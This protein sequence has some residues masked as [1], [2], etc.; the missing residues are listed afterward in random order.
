ILGTDY[1]D[2]TAAP[3]SYVYM[4]RAIALQ[5]NPSGSYFNP[6]QGIFT[7]VSIAPSTTSIVLR[8]T[9]SSNQ[10]TLDWN[11]QSGMSYG[12]ERTEDL[13]GTNWINLT[14]SMAATG[15]HMT[16]SDSTTIAASA[17]FYRVKA[18]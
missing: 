12:V 4:V 16:W 17:H 7:S 11:T 13:T 2:N 6:S 10:V 1:T 14:G 9:R 3:G 8:I 18:E 5:S 15:D